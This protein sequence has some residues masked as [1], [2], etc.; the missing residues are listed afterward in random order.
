M[1]VI[2]IGVLHVV[3]GSQLMKKE[4]VDSLFIGE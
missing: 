4:K 2:F 3:E 1:S